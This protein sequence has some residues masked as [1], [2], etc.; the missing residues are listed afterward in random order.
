[1]S[2]D[3]VAAQ[4]HMSIVQVSSQT[5]VAFHPCHLVPFGTFVRLSQRCFLCHPPPRTG[6]ARATRSKTFVDVSFV[7]FTMYALLSRL[8]ELPRRLQ[9]IPN[10]FTLRDFFLPQLLERRLEGT[11]SCTRKDV[12]VGC[13]DVRL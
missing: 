2:Q 7:V 12:G 6:F 9:L 10:P 11:S 8:G 13:R 5:I 1:M 3:V 4:S